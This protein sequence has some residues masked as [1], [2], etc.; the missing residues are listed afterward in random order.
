[1]GAARD[2]GL[3]QAAEADHYRRRRSTSNALA[4]RPALLNEV[5]ANVCCNAL[6]NG[7]Y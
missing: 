5:L 2:V 3:R 1:M 6:R 7:A 4:R